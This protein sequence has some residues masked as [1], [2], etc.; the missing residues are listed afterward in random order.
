MYKRN[1]LPTKSGRGLG[2]MLVIIALSMDVFTLL[3]TDII[4]QQFKLVD[5]GLLL[6]VTVVIAGVLSGKIILSDFFRGV[7]LLITAFLCYLL[8]QITLAS[9]N[10]NQSLLN[11]FIGS[12]HQQYYLCY[13]V[14][15]AYLRTPL[16]YYRFINILS[17]V[18][19]AVIFISILNYIFPVFFYHK[20]GLGHGERSG[21]VRAFIPG[22]YLISFIAVWE[23][24]KW[25]E[26]ERSMGAR[27]KVA[28]FLA[29]H[30]FRQTR[31]R[32]IGILISYL[33]MFVIR[34]KFVHVVGIFFL[35]FVGTLY[36][37][38]TQKE[39]QWVNLLTSSYSDIS[40][41]SGSWRARQLQIEYAMEE[42]YR[43][44]LTGSGGVA[45]RPEYADTGLSAIAV[46]MLVQKAD[47]GYVHFLKSY[48][49]IGAIWLFAF[50][51]ILLLKSHR[52]FRSSDFQIRLMGLFGLAYIFYVIVT[53]ITINHFMHVD[54]IV[55]LML[56]AALLT[57][58]RENQEFRTTL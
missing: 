41:G 46:V 51:V 14:F 5:V 11:G 13:F 57:R 42:F 50:F 30:V 54:G 35:V 38:A 6:M 39:N 52:L 23:G 7:G 49:V 40:E 1:Y 9:F 31:A 44:P 53:A 37:V 58:V 27:T 17:Y 55:L 43:N 45:L 12:R 20:W 56:L 26:G 29:T 21:I 32:L 2:S 8:F 4:H 19:T 24:A 25:I 10:Y 22:M 18:A 16:E 33:A 48:G 15:L 36:L 3:P 34:R 47:L 28:F